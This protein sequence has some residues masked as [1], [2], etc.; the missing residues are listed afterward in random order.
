MR[1]PADPQS[2][3]KGTI[4]GIKGIAPGFLRDRLSWVELSADGGDEAGTS[5]GGDAS[6]TWTWRSVDDDELFPSLVDLF[7]RHGGSL[8]I[9]QELIWGIIARTEDDM[10]NWDPRRIHL[11]ASIWLEEPNIMMDDQ[12]EADKWEQIEELRLW[13]KHFGGLMSDIV[14]NGLGQAFFVSILGPFSYGCLIPYPYCF[15]AC[16]R[17]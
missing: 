16:C 15:A 10:E 6:K 17:I 1:T 4:Y 11:R 8:E 3:I 9:I 14:N 12:K 2:K 5:G 13:M 7:L